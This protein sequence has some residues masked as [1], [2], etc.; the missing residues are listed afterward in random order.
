MYHLY[1]VAVTS[2]T[3]YDDTYVC[4]PSKALDA[5]ISDLCAYLFLASCTCLFFYVEVYI[6]NI[7]T[8]VQVSPA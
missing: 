5:S 8:L 6:K 1:Y 2:P 3:V 4:L 7:F